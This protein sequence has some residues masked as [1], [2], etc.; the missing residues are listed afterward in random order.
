V[1]HAC[2]LARSFVGAGYKVVVADLLTDET[3]PRYREGLDGLAVRVLFPSVGRVQCVDHFEPA[4][5]G[6][7][8]AVA[9]MDGMVQVKSAS[10][11]AEMLKNSPEIR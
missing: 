2:L 6:V 1:R 5:D 8:Y 10:E 3:W 7:F 9:R 4:P 11:L